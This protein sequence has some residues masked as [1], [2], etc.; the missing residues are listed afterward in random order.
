MQ[1]GN[2][3]RVIFN[4][5]RDYLLWRIIG[6]SGYEYAAAALS[7]NIEHIHLRFTGSI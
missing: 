5:N 2:G 4:K 1:W 3:F 7:R 6:K